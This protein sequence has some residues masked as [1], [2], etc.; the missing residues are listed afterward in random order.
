MGKELAPHKSEAYIKEN[1][2][3][4]IILQQQHLDTAAMA[5]D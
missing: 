4:D 5:F 3:R 2:H 1:K